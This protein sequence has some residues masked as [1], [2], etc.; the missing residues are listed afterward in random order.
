MT[1]RSPSET[2]LENL[3]LSL[4]S[5]I[6]LAV[7]F[8]M[9]ALW[10]LHYVALVPWII[11]I[12]GEERRFTWLY[13][14]AGAYTFFIMAFGALSLFHKAVPFA[15]AALYAPLLIP[16][17]ILLRVVYRQL[18]LPL[19]LLVPVVWV[20]TEW[21]R[22]HFSLG[23]MGFFPL[24]SSQFNR[25]TLIQIADITGVYGISF[26]V[27]GANGFVVDLW[28]LI[29][30]KQHPYTVAA[31]GCYGAL[32]LA[33]LAYGRTR[34]QALRFLPGPRI[35]IVQPNAIHYQDPRRAF[36]TYQQQATFTR[37]TVRPGS[38]DVI[39]WPEN[40]IGQPLS[41][42]PRYVQGLKQLAHDEGAYLLVGGYTWADSL[43]PAGHLH[44]SA[45]YFSPQG[46]IVGRYD[47]IH[48][49]PYSEYTPFRGWPRRLGAGLARALLG[50]SGVGVPGT[51]VVR[52]AIRAD[53]GGGLLQFAVPICFEVSSSGFAR[54]AAAQGASFL[55][56]ITSEGL[57][58]PPMYVHMLAQSTLRAVENRIAVVRVANNGLSGFV[59]PV[60]RAHLIPGQGG[61]G[62]SRWLFREAGMRVERVPVT[63]AANA[64]F[65]TRHGEWLAY[66]CIGLTL[67]LLAFAAVRMRSSAVNAP[68]TDSR[69]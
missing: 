67:V 65:Y 58:G 41:D 42:D 7:P 17:A 56:N 34:E 26:L 15:V 44:T 52:F 64:T 50:Y 8:L 14:F 5:G 31:F 43:P 3:A 63:A 9:P 27:A 32:V 48:M 49:I 20:S 25:T 16:F 24:G 62:G 61:T 30:R 59:D 21:L 22:L 55:V 10:W 69:P 57:L 13:F 39:A 35:A 47:K 4:L 29:R 38:A 33:V 53:S 60:G 2:V 6:L 46:A 37:A 40:A 11:L 28:P 51:E 18:R 1:G 12:T 54:T 45:Y 19:T 36:E 66:C 23:E 68:P